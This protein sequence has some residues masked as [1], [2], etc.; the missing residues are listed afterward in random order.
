MQH[1][2]LIKPRAGAAHTADDG[3]DDKT[4]E[5]A[6]IVGG[7]SK[8]LH[9]AD[10]PHQE[11]AKAPIAHETVATASPAG[12]SGGGGGGGPGS[13]S[14]SDTSTSSDSDSATLG[15]SSDLSGTSFGSIPG[16]MSHQIVVGGSPAQIVI[17]EPGTGGLS[18]DVSIVGGSGLTHTATDIV[19]TLTGSVSDILAPVG[20]GGL[21]ASVDL[22]NLLGFDLHVNSN[23][24]FIATDLSAA[25][26]QSPLV[27]IANTV[28][29][30]VSPVVDGLPV[31]SFGTSNAL[32]SL[33][34]AD[35][36]SSAVGHLG[37]LSSILGND[38]IGSDDATSTLKGIFSGDGT[39]SLDKLADTSPATSPDGSSNTLLPIAGGAPDPAHVS[40][41]GEATSVTPGHSIDFPT[42]VS[43]EGD[44][45][46][47]GN[48]YTDY[49]VALQTIGP[50]VVSNSVTTALSSVASTTHDTASL[51]HVDSPV[52]NPPASSGRA[53]DAASGCVARS[54]HHDT[55]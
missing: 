20:L 47:H 3:Q 40:I 27:P 15:S 16:D 37:D 54:H 55:R 14:S 8:A 11:H 51:A 28:S 26:D 36:H 32:D 44:V 23:G 38:D 33:F 13:T 18:I 52:P 17:G 48:S 21:S 10:L 9:N 42:P 39:A 31:L 49:H 6:R 12:D 46:F 5:R 4:D 35:N 2:T 7:V 29:N 50:S 25:L 34:G 1:P 43:P 19:S 53:D 24:E 45:L 41:I 30:V 22:K